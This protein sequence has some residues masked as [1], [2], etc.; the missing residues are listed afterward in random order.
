MDDVAHHHAV[1]VLRIGMA[2][3]VAEAAPVG[4]ANMGNA[5]GGAAHLG[6]E[7]G[8]F[9]RER[10]GADAEQADDSAANSAESQAHR[11]RR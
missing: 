1:V 9:L 8:I 10:A 5:V 7:A 11:A 6:R 4:G 2:Q 3:A